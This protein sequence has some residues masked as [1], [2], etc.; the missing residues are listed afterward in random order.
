MDDLAVAGIAAA[1]PRSE[2]AGLVLQ[3]LPLDRD[4]SLRDLYA[5][6]TSRDPAV[7]ARCRAEGGGLTVDRGV[8]LSF[9]TYFGAFFELHWRGAT[10]LR[11]VVLDI[12]ARGSFALRVCR[13]SPE[14]E[15]TTLHEAVLLRSEGWLSIPLP[16]PLVPGAG[17]RLFAE[18]EA[19]ADGAR[20]DAL[21]WRTPDTAVPAEVGLVP[22]FCTFGREERFG[23]VLS[24]L[25]AEPSC[26]E[27]LP[28]LVVVN[29]GR[30]DLLAHPAFAGLPRD[31]LSRLLVVEQGNFGGAGGFTRGLLEARGVPG[32]T[33]ALLMD[34][35]VAAEPEALRRAAAFF[36]IALPRHAL[37][38]HMLD[39]LR[40]T[41]LYEAGALVDTER[42]HAKP[43]KFGTPLR[44]RG[45]LDAVSRPEP[46]HFNGWWFFGLPLA[47][48]EE[49]GLPLPCFIRGDD[50]EFGLRL[51]GL[52]AVTVA[53]PGAAIWHEPF[54]VKLN[55]WQLFYEIRNALVAAAV[56][57]P[58][59][60][61]R[62]AMMLLKRLL[63]Y[64][65]TFRYYSAALLLR[66]VEDYLRGPA[67][68]EADP[69]ATH[70]LLD[71]DKTGFPPEEVERGR[72]LPEGRLR[73]DPRSRLGFVLVLVWAVLRNWVVPVR[74]G[75][76]VRI[77]AADLLWFRVVGLD[78]VVAETHWDVRPPVFRR[79]RGAFRHLLR[80][81]I[82]V[83]WRVLREG[84]D[85][86]RLWRG[87]YGRLTS[88]VFW[89]GYLRGTVRDGEG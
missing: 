50:V 53:L 16:A 1:R 4:V 64:L 17:G 86:S 58:R 61:P 59:P 67:A 77:H 23:A 76:A 68:F 39:M 37:G 34:D 7:P 9:D 51:H 87:G 44:E 52:G 47:L 42:L 60:A 19:L 89:R 18:V 30:P 72:V 56:H 31:F 27:G 10:G 84:P 55:G 5:R 33:H 65:L 62:L 26:W 73:R 63:F 3:R 6:V 54:Y 41:H 14:G 66:G 32:A 2:R 25:A 28:C 48:L 43:L 71:Q 22:V 85:V 81:G 49:A 29:Q 79:S 38:G 24:T 69:R 45:A 35:D 82:E 83:V 40:P 13:R 15:E 12:Q 78:H 75:E 57:M 21:E 11:S 70:A 88:E 80:R 74:P 36:A 46:M 20:V 8:T